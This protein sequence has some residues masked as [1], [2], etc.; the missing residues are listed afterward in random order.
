[1]RCSRGMQQCLIVAIPLF[2][3]GSLYAAAVGDIPTQY[4]SLST[5]HRHT[6]FL[7]FFMHTI[8]DT[9]ITRIHQARRIPKSAGSHL[10][11]PL[12]RIVLRPMRHKKHGTQEAHAC[13]SKT[14][15]KVGTMVHGEVLYI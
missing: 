3:C 13:E 11:F 15:E 12:I 8:A 6:V 9:H 10:L 2:F 7:F 5:C 4:R 1:M 14:N